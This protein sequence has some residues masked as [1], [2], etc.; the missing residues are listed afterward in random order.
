MNNYI[1]L[2]NLGYIN[3]FIHKKKEFFKGII[4]NNLYDIQKLFLNSNWF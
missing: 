3:I 4:L 2:Q 1:H